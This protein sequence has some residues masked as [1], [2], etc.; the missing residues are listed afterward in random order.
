MKMR[1]KDQKNLLKVGFFVTGLVIVLLIMVVSIGKQNSIFNPKVDIMARVGNVSALKVGSY[2]ELKGIQIGSVTDISIISDEEVE[3]TME[4]LKDQLKWI[5][6]DSRVSISTAGLVGD[7]FVEIY[8]GTHE[9]AVFRPLKDVLVSEENSDFKKILTKGDTIASITE[10]I[11]AKIDGI[12]TGLDDGKKVVEMVNSLNRAS[13]HLD[14]V[15]SDVRKANAGQA[16]KNVNAAMERMTKATGSLERILARVENGPGTANSLIYD[17]GVHEDLRALLGGAERN[18]V[19][20]YFI[21]ESIRNSEQK[22][23]SN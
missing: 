13:S 3:I 12:L 14:E 4:I 8:K 7:K 2:V 22:K 15:M 11:M 10:R 20:K 17:E 16:V 5:K 9:G 6:Q 18:K 1:Q 19:I 21:R 23:K